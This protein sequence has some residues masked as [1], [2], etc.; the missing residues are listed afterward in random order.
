[1]TAISIPRRRLAVPRRPH[2][3][4]QARREARWGLIF[5]SPWIIG[6]FAFTLLPMFALLA[7]TYTTINLHKNEPPSVAG[8]T[9]YSRL[10][11]DPQAWESL[12]VTL[13]FAVLALP[14]SVG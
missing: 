2:L 7:F 9:N 3:S 12:G 8:I 6:F 13:R 14:I 1:M 4:P 5:I 10:F 11:S